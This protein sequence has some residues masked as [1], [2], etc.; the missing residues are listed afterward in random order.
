LLNGFREFFEDFQDAQTQ[1]Q[2]LGWSNPEPRD[3]IFNPALVDQYL[4]QIIN[5]IKKRRLGLLRD[6]VPQANG[7]RRIDEVDS[8]FGLPQSFA[9]VSPRLRAYLEKIF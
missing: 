2:I 8:L 6:P 3:T 1:H 4:E 7:G 5:R 9:L